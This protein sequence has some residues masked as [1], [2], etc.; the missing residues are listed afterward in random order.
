MRYACMILLLVG[1][2][3]AAPPLQSAA[4]RYSS[5]QPQVI[6]WPQRPGNPAPPTPV[7]LLYTP[8]VLAALAAAS[9]DAVSPRIARATQEQTPIVV[10][11]TIPAPANAEPWPRPF[12]TVIV[13]PHGDSFGFPSPG[14]GVRVEPLWVEQQADDLRLLDRRTEFTDVGVMA[15]YPRSAFVPG[16][17]IT[18]YLRLPREVGRGTGVQRYGLI[19]WSGVT[20]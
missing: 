3:G 13:E 18:I 12:S 4:P 19:Q 20:P 14:S 7:G 6:F 2:I 10:L 11:W 1:V 9:P 17:L 15:G 8:E 5:V 16:R